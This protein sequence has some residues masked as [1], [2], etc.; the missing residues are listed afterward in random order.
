[1]PLAMFSLNGTTCK[2]YFKV[3]NPAR[4]EKVQVLGQVE[5]RSVF[6][7]FHCP[8]CFLYD[9]HRTGVMNVPNCPLPIKVLTLFC[10]RTGHANIES[11]KALN[12]VQL[13]VL[14]ESMAY[15]DNLQAVVAS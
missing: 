11:A 6:N 7:K 4:T 15:T 5:N 12:H 3:Y 1:M 14:R 10:G 2:I 9:M 8:K 13:C